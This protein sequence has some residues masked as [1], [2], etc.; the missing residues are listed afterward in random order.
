MKWKVENGIFI[1]E[2]LCDKREDLHLEE[3]GIKVESDEHWLPVCIDLRVMA[4]IRQ[5]SPEGEEANWTVMEGIAVDVLYTVK[6]DWNSLMPYFI[7]SR[8]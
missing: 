5:R 7:E 2:T 8:K 3:M 4:S 1:G 6:A